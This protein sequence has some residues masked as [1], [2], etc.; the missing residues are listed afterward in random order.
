MASGFWSYFG[1]TPTKASP[2]TDKGAARAQYKE[3]ERLAEIAS[4]KKIAEQKVSQESSD[5]LL[6]SR[7]ANVARE[8][9]RKAAEDKLLADSNSANRAGLSKPNTD[10]I[11]LPLVGTGRTKKK[12]VSNDSTGGSNSTGGPAR[13]TNSGDTT[14]N[15]SNVA[16]ASPH[17][18]D[19]AQM[20]QQG[21]TQSSRD[22]IL[23]ENVLN[24][25]VNYTYVFTLSG[26]RKSSLSQPTID[27][28]EAD[29]SAYTILKSSG[30]GANYTM[31]QRSDGGQ[32]DAVD[33]I[34]GFNKDSPGR[35]D[36][37]ID[38]IE[39]DTLLTFSGK[40][41]PT[42]PLTMR[43]EVYEPYSINGFMEALQAAA[44][45]C[46]YTN[47]ATASF[48]L[49]MKFI[50]YEDDD[51]NAIEPEI[52]MSTRYFG[53]KI[54]K[55]ELDVTAKGTRY[56]CVG[57]P[58]NEY[59]FSDE[60]NKL[61]QNVQVNGST[62]QEVL[63]NFMDELEYQRWS[64]N[65][66]A[67]EKTGGYTL[68]RDKYKVV[69]EDSSGQFKELQ[70]TKLIPNDLKENRLFVMDNPQE[71]PSVR[72]Y[73]TFATSTA[74]YN[75][76][77]SK[78]TTSRAPS[79]DASVL[80]FAANSNITDCIAAV[81][82]DSQWSIKLL[83]NLYVDSG[84]PAAARGYDPETGLL[85]YFVV[86]VDVK[87]QTDLDVIRNRPYQ[88]FTYIIKPFKIHYTLIPG[89]Q[90]DKFV[91][92]DK[93]LKHLI[94]RQ[95]DY[96][97][98]AKNVDILDFKIN[99]NNSMYA[100]MPNAMG[101]SSQSSKP[102]VVG[103]STNYGKGFSPENPEKKLA[104]RGRDLA[105]AAN[106]VNPTLLTTYD[107]TRASGSINAGQPSLNPYYVQS[108]AMY[109]SLVKNPF[110]MVMVELGIIG[111]PVYLAMG[112][113][114]NF[115]PKSSNGVITENGSIN[116]NYGIPYIKINFR[117]PKDIDPSGFLEFDKG[118]IEFSGIYMVK[119][120][121]SKFANGVFT[122]RMTLARMS[123]T[124]APK[125]GGT[126][127]VNSS[128]PTNSTD[129]PTVTEQVIISDVADA[130][131]REAGPYNVSLQAA[132]EASL[133][134]GLLGLPE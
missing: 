20:K 68:G 58:F 19:P 129:A 124:S 34:R 117:N 15:T 127:M 76:K 121:T 81:I 8:N 116:Q 113:V 78:T 84:N 125:P 69:F 13:F 83:E 57:L 132:R 120:V 102:A 103:A 77:V 74:N 47:Y 65:N 118:R 35:F 64:S 101:K 111:D 86:R 16:G 122:Q 6:V 130:F 88:D 128:E 126:S 85:D 52:P 32:P 38:N 33:F 46:G 42:L 48:L 91:Y 3:K 66:K 55:V 18:R 23:G 37:Y 123:Q 41:G 72:L 4:N 45:G 133:K 17:Q 5:R 22:T 7:N 2:T 39:I 26:L 44:L 115:D 96:I 28:F 29:S 43:F 59:A 100:M 98:T 10:E 94:L 105:T 21:Q 25:Y 92:Q 79:H 82:T 87:N 27:T 31:E 104:I 50:G 134:R 62:V 63:T 119:Q 106:A 108:K 67:Y 90:Q 99:F 53:M 75:N 40:S 60:I 73:G 12:S 89:H 131:N 1:I 11:G 70:N 93:I 95:Y 54:T 80:H 61:H 114:S 56:T 112:G 71:S 24:D 9:A 49:K 36:M 107:N 30:K 14:R 97:Y 51:T 110:D 109:E